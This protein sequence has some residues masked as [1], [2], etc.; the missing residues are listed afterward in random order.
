[1]TGR[2]ASSNQSGP[3]SGC[4]PTTPTR[5][6]R[7]APPRR[8]RPRWVAARHARRPSRLEHE[9]RAVLEEQG[10]VRP[11]Q[12]SVTRS[13]PSC[14]VAPGVSIH[15]WS[16]RAAGRTR[17]SP[18]RGGRRGRSPGS[19]RHPGRSRGSRAGRASASSRGA[20][21]AAGLRV[22]G[23]TGQGVRGQRQLLARADVADVE[24]VTLGR[25]QRGDSLGA[26]LGL[27]GR[28]PDTPGRAAGQRAE[29]PRRVNHRSTPLT[30]DPVRRPGVG[31][32]APRPR[33]RAGAAG[34]R[35]RG[36][37]DPGL[38]SRAQPDGPISV[39]HQTGGGV[40]VPAHVRGDVGGPA[41]SRHGDVGGPARSRRRGD[42]RGPGE[43]A[44]TVDLRGRNA[45]EACAD[46]IRMVRP[47]RTPGPR[48]T[49][50]A[51]PASSRRGPPGAAPG[52]PPPCPGR[53]RRRRPAGRGIGDRGDTCGGD[54]APPGAGRGARPS[55]AGTAASERDVV[56]DHGVVE[57]DRAGADGRA[58]ADGAPST[59]S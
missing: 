28:P 46:R 56:A 12:S 32:G 1:M 43:R 14:T 45:P 36:V 18:R 47:G 49:R 16:P 5:P 38:G 44:A 40:D 30:R 15:R 55:S 7:T 23:G 42:R 6:H 8:R 53:A 31:G 13:S 19:D 59:S 51:P 29:G 26:P 22:D 10:P 9:A 57:H 39:A 4:G 58:V 37:A 33:G 24:A 35:R 27:G 50:R 17:A 48:P 21:C 52:S 11:A 3:A 54:A 41:R 2:P 25:E 34:A 20:E